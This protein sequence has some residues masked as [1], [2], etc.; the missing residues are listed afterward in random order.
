MNRMN[1]SDRILSSESESNI[2]D[3]TVQSCPLEG[4]SLAYGFIHNLLSFGL[5]QEILVFHNLHS[6]IFDLSKDDRSSLLLLCT[7]FLFEK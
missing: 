3:V 1:D 4:E 2:S 7:F 5:G 6:L